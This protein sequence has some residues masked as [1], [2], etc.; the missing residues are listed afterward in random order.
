MMSTTT[1]VT[2]VSDA[3]ESQI[4]VPIPSSSSSTKLVQ[5]AECECCELRE[6][7]TQGYI[8]RIRERY[9]GK[10]ICGLCAEA[11]KDE[12]IRSDRLITTEEALILHINFCKKFISSEGPISD[13]TIDLIAAMRQILLRSLDN[14][15]IRSLRSA[16]R[17]VGQGIEVLES[18]IDHLLISDQSCI[19]ASLSSLGTD[20]SLSFPVICKNKNEWEKGN[21]DDDDH[22]FELS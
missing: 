6:E 10:W 2:V 19:A 21:D 15:P 1:T 3:V 5:F 12:I 4:S 8:E 20:S 17:S 22:D 14:S 16:P 18:N 13:P 11:V 7:C 9:Q